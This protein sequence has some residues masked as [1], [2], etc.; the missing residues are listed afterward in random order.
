MDLILC[1]SV[2]LF[3]KGRQ[4][5]IPFSVFLCLCVKGEAASDRFQ[6]LLPFRTQK[7]NSMQG[8]LVEEEGIERE[9]QC[10]DRP[11]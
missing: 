10:I 9:G 2:L 5:S 3:E 6:C 1:G 4:V 7:S 11:G 8:T